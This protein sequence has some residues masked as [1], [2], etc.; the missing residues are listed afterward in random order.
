MD[1]VGDFLEDCC[2]EGDKES[3]TVKDLYLEYEDWAKKE[4]MNDREIW[5]KATLTL[6]LKDR[7]FEQFRDSRNGTRCWNRLSI[8][9]GGLTS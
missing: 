1:I 9:R 3:V 8:K 7:G 4:G 2:I 6:R 5:K